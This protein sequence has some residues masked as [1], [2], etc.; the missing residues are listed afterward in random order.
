MK[1]ST[2]HKILIIIAILTIL[3]LGFISFNQVDKKTKGPASDNLQSI[4]EEVDIEG[5]TNS[6]SF[7]DEELSIEEGLPLQ[8]QYPTNGITVTNPSLTISGITMPQ[9]DLFI[10]EFELNADSQGGFSL[11]L[12]LEEGENIIV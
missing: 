2:G 12:I 11:P 9:A 10:N 8:I 3:V 6:E 5:E 4:E 7:P 1:K